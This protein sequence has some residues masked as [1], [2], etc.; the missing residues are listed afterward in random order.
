M[1]RFILS[2]ASLLL[3]L[4]AAIPLVKATT[5][6]PSPEADRQTLSEKAQVD[7][8]IVEWRWDNVEI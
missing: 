3:A 7:A 5:G 4:T 6:V 2:S 1:K 8:T